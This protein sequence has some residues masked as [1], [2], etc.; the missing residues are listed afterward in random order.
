MKLDLGISPCPNDTFIFEALVHQLI[1]TNDMQFITHFADIET[2]NNWALSQKY[3]LL[4]V[5]F[6]VWNQ[7]KHNY[8]LLDSGSALGN[9]VGP[10]LISK[11]YHHLESLENKKIGIPGKHTT[12][13]VLF[14]SCCKMNTLK[15]YLPFQTLEKKII[16]NELDAA[17]IIHE[18]RFTY[19]E[20]G[21][22][23]IIDLGTYWEALYHLPIPLGGIVLHKSLA[24]HQEK[25]TNF[26]KQSLNY[27]WQHHYPNFSNFIL[28]HAQNMQ[29]EVVKKHID[30]YVNAFSLSLGSI[31]YN[32]IERLTN[33]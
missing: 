28:E 2:L 15:I 26:I 27:A 7:I 29:P 13:H 5:S 23:K 14:N 1:D 32:A 16:D 17:V 21:L 8:I 20:L 10:I 9:G 31:G 12:A 33:P 22:H 30:L 19:Q 4:K 11:H 25:I 24:K 6:G 18:S 3:P